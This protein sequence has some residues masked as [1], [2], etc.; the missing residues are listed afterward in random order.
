MLPADSA[1]QPA[2]LHP[3]SFSNR[4]SSRYYLGKSV[5][6]VHPVFHLLASLARPPPSLAQRSERAFA[7]TPAQSR[8]GRDRICEAG[9]LPLMCSGS[10]PRS[11]CLPRAVGLLPTCQA[12]TADHFERSP[13]QMCGDD[14][15]P[16]AGVAGNLGHLTAKEMWGWLPAVP[17]EPSAVDWQRTGSGKANG[18]AGRNT[19]ANGSPRR[20]RGFSRGPG[21]TRTCDQGIMSPLL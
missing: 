15:S 5:P 13:P 10:G 12:D 1:I 2:H 20:S 7:R 9:P 8:G 18:K 11:R 4:R 3:S 16:I 14:L 21:R 6:Q 17:A 19:R